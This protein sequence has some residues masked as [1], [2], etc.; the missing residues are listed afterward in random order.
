MR[1]RILG[2][3]KPAREEVQQTCPYLGLAHDQFS[4]LPEPSSEH[5][6]F[7]Y[8]QRERIDQSHQQRFCLT[9][10]YPT[11]P[12]LMVNP[13]ASSAVQPKRPWQGVW[14]DVRERFDELERVTMRNRWPRALAML[15]LLLGQLIAKSAVEG[16]RIARPVIQAFLLRLWLVLQVAARRLWQASNRLIQRP[17]RSAQVNQAQVMTAGS[18]VAT[19]VPETAKV[20]A[21]G[22]QAVAARTADSSDA[23]PVSTPMPVVAATP[24]VNGRVVR[25]VGRWECASC[26]KYNAA[27]ATFCQYCG[28]LSSEVERELLASEDFFALDGLKALAAGDEDG[29]HRYFTLAT[30]ANPKSELA[31]RWKS[32]TASTLNDVIQTLEQMLAANPDSGEARADLNLALERREREQA[33]AAARALAQQ[34]EVVPKGPSLAVRVLS[35]VRRLALEL[36]SIP[37]FILGLLWLGQPVLDALSSI[38]IHGVDGVMPIFKLPRFEV[39]LPPDLVQPLLPA[40]FNLADVAPIAL[41]LWY[42]FLAFRVADGSSGARYVGIVSGL[43]SIGASYY[44]LASN[45]RVFLIA[46]VALLVLSL[47]GKSVHHEEKVTPRMAVVRV[48]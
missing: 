2:T 3:G 29:A 41:A 43:A 24:P 18:T 30:Q 14:E 8:M 46:A 48:A 38:G 22:D 34:A 13:A 47:V 35:V 7:L 42:L 37:S 21:L 25:P 1:G 20:E 26:F 28:R 15:A 33:L 32:R 19:A 36:A 27:S 39:S 4:H 5:R 23:K 12:W 45:G 11:C 31:W 44:F 10:T 16:W 6:C 17:S 40:T 9:T